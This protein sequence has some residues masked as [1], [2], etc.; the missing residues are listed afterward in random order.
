M[1]EV[2]VIT[3]DGPS[4]SG[5]GTIAEKVAKILGYHLLDSGALYR[6]VGCIAH[7]RKLDF[8]NP[9][10]LAEL[11]GKL[12]IGFGEAGPGTVIVDGQDLSS[13][14][15][16]EKG[17]ELASLMGAIPEVRMALFNRQ[18]AF[19]RAPGLVADGR[20]MGTVV[21][22]DAK[23]KIFLT[24][25]PK[26][27]ANRR[28]KQLIAKGIGA[29]L[30]GLLQELKARDERDSN[31]FHSPLRPAHDA[32]IIDTTAMPVDEVMAKVLNLVRDLNV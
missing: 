2:P 5:K 12:A 22:P 17:G 11:A 3:I 28:Y 23:V 8:N 10:L 24:A 26:E 19:R 4:G 27:R 30:P 15:R 29:T 18:L 13:E 25:S 9:Q 32:H 7:A 20:D 31:R 14:I 6:I 1:S 21:F 16:Q